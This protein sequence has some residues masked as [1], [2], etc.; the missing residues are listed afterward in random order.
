MESPAD[1]RREKDNLQVDWGSP[2]AGKGEGL[3]TGRVEAHLQQI[4][5]RAYLQVDWCS[6]AAGKGEGLLGGR[7]EHVNS[8]KP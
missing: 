5:E 8:G 3:L 1:F 4:G 7:V 6:A 2:A